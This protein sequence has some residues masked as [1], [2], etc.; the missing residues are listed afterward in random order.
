LRHVYRGLIVILLAVLYLD[1]DTAIGVYKG[2]GKTL[3][4]TSWKAMRLFTRNAKFN[5][6]LLRESVSDI[7]G[8]YGMVAR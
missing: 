7:V 6:E 8:K 3:F 2:F 5:E 1:I 4:G